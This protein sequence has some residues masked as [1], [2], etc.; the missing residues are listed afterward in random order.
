[1]ALVSPGI[2]ISINDQSQYV[3]SNVGSVPL[4][5]LATAQDKTSNGSI[6][7]GTTKANAGKLLAFTSQRDLINQMG[8]PSFQVSSSGTPV[9]ASETNEYGLL[10]AYSALGI[11]N[12]LFAIRADIDLNQLIGTSVRP[13]AAPADGTYWLDTVN[14]DWGLSALTTNNTFVDVNPIVVTNPNQV[15]FY[16]INGTTNVPVPASTVGALGSY[17]IVTVKPDG[18]TPLSLRLFYKKTANSYN[19]NS[20]GAVGTPPAAN[21]WVDVASPEWQ[22]SIPVVT[23]TLAPTSIPDGSTFTINNHG[24]ITISGPA[25]VSQVAVAINTSAIPGVF[26]SV[27]S[28]NHLMLFVT[29]A[30]KSNNSTVNGQLNIVDGRNS[31]LSLLGIKPSSGTNNNQT[32]NNPS[33]NYF[34]PYFFYGD[35]A[36]QP[37]GGW[38]ASDANPRPAGSIWW[39]TSAL[40]GGYN[41][42]FKTYSANSGTFVATPVP[43]YSGVAAATTALDPVAGGLNIS[44]GQVISTYTVADTTYNSLRYYVK[45]AAQTTTATGGLTT[46][47]TAD[48]GSSIQVLVT[49]P[50]TTAY[51]SFTINLSNDPALGTPAPTAATFVSDLLAAG[52]PF[53]QVALNTVG[54]GHTIT[55]NH[56]TGGVIQLVNVSGT[57]SASAGF[58]AGQGSGFAINVS[59]SLVFISNFDLI[60]TVKYQATAPYATPATG[61]YWNYS[62]LADVDIMVND[63]GWKGYRNVT[64]DVRGFNLHQTDVNG[65]IVSASQPKSQSTGAQLVL[66]DLWLNSAAL[67]EE[68][69]PNLYRVTAVDGQG[70]ASWSAINNTDHVS[71]SGIIFADTRWDTNGTTNVITDS[72][73]AITDLLTSN[74]IDLDAPDWRLYPRGTLLFNTRRSGYNVKKFVSN[75]FNSLSFAVPS[76]GSNP[77]NYPTAIPEVTDAWVNASGLD[78]NG[79][80]YAG[81]YAQRALVVSA[82][83]SAIDSNL[84]VLSPVYQFNLIVAPAYPE[85]IPNML[86]LNA[87]RGN[88]AFVIGDT[89]LDLAPNTVD[90]TEWVNNTQGTG[91][92]SDASISPYLALYY[93][94][95]R[96]NDLAG[97]QVVVPASHAVLRT[98]LYNDQVSYPWFAPAGTQRGLITNLNDIGYVNGE[99][100]TFVHNSISQ[101]LRDALF[102][103][104]INPLTQLPG[105]GLTVFGQLTR[106]GSTTSRNRVNVVRLENYLR[107]VFNSVA[108]GYLFE[109]NDGTTR[110]SIAS[111]IESA[112]HNVL[113][114]RGLYDFLVICDTSNNTPATISNNQLY[115]DVAIEPM[116]DVEFIYIPIAIYNPGTIAALNTSST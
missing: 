112:L 34:C 11:S 66:G 88:T 13:I 49:T 99:A 114:N 6:A 108:N 91:L 98:F 95:G 96:T 86:T 69:Y 43:F 48:I 59:P 60:S 94:A 40:G 109:P 17:A 78:E 105:I 46:F 101:G 31:P 39:K 9:N 56:T 35:F 52:I 65:V 4:V 1:M 111:Q 5:I 24:A 12:Q 23:G 116:K 82:M 47:S 90:I 33:G 21:T 80:M 107:T 89:P 70:N 38:F 19:L 41:P 54:S 27:D 7:V 22:Q 51:S 16:T 25:T 55:L 76:S 102:T 85:V 29:S 26:A 18:T 32:T 64:S 103:L 79:V 42:V 83:Q 97:N 75:Y 74:Y 8:T 68:Q 72:F 110:K 93:P 30:A 61:T 15:S 53:L 62:N 115:V 81:L 44:A 45:K 104:G 3:A 73:P 92:P 67:E 87:N 77:A 2:S 58:V 57:P 63:N 28:S 100:G 71:S 106:S 37:S 36:A 10:A 84:D 14:T 20:P 50:G 113:A